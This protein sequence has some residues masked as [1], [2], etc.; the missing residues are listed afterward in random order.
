MNEVIIEAYSPKKWFKAVL[1]G[2]L[3]G[4]AVIVPGVSGA[5]IAIIFGMYGMLLFAVG[6]IFKSFKKCFA[7]LLPIALGLIFGFIVGLL[8]VQKFFLAYPFVLICLFCGL[9]TG[10]MPAVFNNIKGDQWTSGRVALF[11]IGLIIPILV[12]VMSLVLGGRGGSEPLMFSVPKLIF[13]LIL[14]FVVS[15]TQVVPGLSAT[16]LLLAVGEF[17]S[18]L[19]SLH[20]KYLVH[21]PLILVVFVAL[22]VGFVAGLVVFSK[23]TAA[24]IS[25]NKAASFFAI[26]GL[27]VGA[28]ISMLLCP[29]IFEVYRVWNVE[30]VNWIEL[31]GGAILLV[32]GIIS[33]FSL[34]KYEKNKAIND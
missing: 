20:L 8:V 27:S 28:V 16:A 11:I 1:L 13:Y 21:N 25:K 19:A 4:L 32:I 31:V 5:T 14:G 6:N 24:F 15:L 17:G 7:F 22:G 34:V 26:S 30:G 10:A 12:S 29:E 33:A 23:I 9:M 18:M 2:V 3:L